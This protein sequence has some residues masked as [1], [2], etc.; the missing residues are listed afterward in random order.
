VNDDMW[1]AG[2]C[3]KFMMDYFLRFKL[4]CF[5]FYTYIVIIMYL[6]IVYD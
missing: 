6:D 4:Q 3:L 2:P 1:H 5:D